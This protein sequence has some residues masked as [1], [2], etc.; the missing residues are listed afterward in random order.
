MDKA[1]PGTYRQLP[2]LPV[3]LEGS[4]RPGDDRPGGA[5]L[6]AG[7]RSAGARETVRLI[8][9]LTFLELARP[10]LSRAKFDEMARTIVAHL[11]ARG[12]TAEPP[13]QRAAIPTGLEQAMNDQ[14][15]DLY[16]EAWHGERHGINDDQAGPA[17]PFRPSFPVAGVGPQPDA[18]ADGRSPRALPP[19]SRDVQQQVYVVTV[20]PAGDGRNREMTEGL[21]FP[22]RRSSPSG[23]ACAT[24]ATSPS[25]PACWPGA[26]AVGLAPG[27]P[28]CGRP[29]TR[30]AATPRPIAIRRG[31][32]AMVL[33]SEVPPAASVPDPLAEALAA[34]TAEAEARWA[35]LD[36]WRQ[37]AELLRAEIAAAEAAL[38]DAVEALTRNRLAVVRGEAKPSSTAA[39]LERHRA[40][41]DALAELREQEAV[42]TAEQA[43]AQRSHGAAVMARTAAEMR[44]KAAE[45]M[46][47][48]EASDAEIDRLLAPLVEVLNRRA[49][50][51][52]EFHELAKGAA[53]FDRN[54]QAAQTV[55]RLDPM[56]ADLRWDVARIPCLAIP[57]LFIFPPDGY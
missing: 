4:I 22:S 44:T 38:A 46:A 50:L 36:T 28:A 19:L 2:F 30:A 37:R 56:A 27:R 39:L 9:A 15:R 3:E 13:Y 31:E 1:C 51:G 45:L 48:A 41:S 5:G 57:R 40:V 35:E 43:A 33:V 52:Q 12:I 14:P 18:S 25:V 34:A 23:S 16:A 7:D 6:D 26:R 47:E 53:D 24:A 10:Y 29:I 42:L 11:A 32:P 8:A 17:T 49:L 21:P 54:P 20:H 55:G